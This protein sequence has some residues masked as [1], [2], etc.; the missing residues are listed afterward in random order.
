MWGWGVLF[1]S[2]A[3]G[4]V[5]TEVSSP[6]VGLEADTPLPQGLSVSAPPQLDLL[7]FPEAAPHPLPGR[8]K[9]EVAEEQGAFLR[10]KPQEH[11]T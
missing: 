10:G 7:S 9:A 1:T 5:L 8:H 6:A 3:P 4:G 11:F 2:A